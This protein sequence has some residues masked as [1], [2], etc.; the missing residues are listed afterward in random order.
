MSRRR[1]VVATCFAL[2]LAVPATSSA[3]GFAIREQSGSFQGLSFAGVAAGGPD[4]STMY[5][6][7]ATLTLHDGVQ[8]HSSVSFI[9][10]RAELKNANASDPLGRPVVGPDGGNITESAIVP[11]AYGAIAFGNF[12]FGLGVTAPFGLSTDAPNDWIGRYQATRSELTTVNVN[13]VIAWQAHERVSVAAGFVAQYA[14]AT[15]E[16]AVF[17]R[18]SAVVGA[19]GDAQAKVKGSDWDYGFTLGALAE[20]IDGTRI[21]V[22]YRSQINHSV[23][24]DFELTAPNGA[25]ARST[26]GRAAVSTPQILSLGA[27]QQLSD[28]WSLKGT[29]EWTGWSSFDELVVTFDDGSPSSVTQEQWRDTWFFAAGAEYLPRPDVR[30]QAGVAY[31]QTPIREGFRTPRIPDADRTWVSVGALW[32]PNGWLDVGA[33]YSHIFVDDGPVNLQEPG[34][35]GSIDGTFESRIDIVTLHGTIR[36]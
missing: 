12:R 23:T 3:S 8:G 10:P 27:S 19:A 29:V 6:N 35:R 21:G 32:Q 11:A 33:G 26:G 30:L 24:G 36:F 25:L 31:D 7:P 2:T 18:A 13:P 1:V 34:G 5:F 22:G 4:I 9:F 16:N 28:Q 20:P 15:L 14:H 17:T